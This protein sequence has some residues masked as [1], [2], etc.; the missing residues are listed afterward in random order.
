MKTTSVL[1][2]C[3][4]VLSVTTALGLAQGAV[5]PPPS[6]AKAGGVT[7]EGNVVVIPKPPDPVI[8]DGKNAKDLD[9][10]QMREFLESKIQTIYQSEGAVEILKVAP[11]YALT[12]TFNEPLSSVVVGDPALVNFN[13]KGKVLVLSA[14]ARAGDTSMQIILPGDRILNY[15]IFIAPNFADAQSTLNVIVGAG[16]RGGEGG[17]G[18]PYYRPDEGLD[19]RAIANIISN[20]DALIEEGAIS[21]SGI[22]R[23]GIF[24]KSDLTSFEYYYI[25]TFKGG[26]VAISFAYTNPFSYPIRYDESRLRLQMGNM[27]FIPDYVSFNKVDLGP[28]EVSTGFAVIADPGF[29]PSQPFELNW[30]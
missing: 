7:T 25:Y 11:G 8:V 30:K 2:V 3:A 28:G 9:E 29:V 27:L 17:G 5:P 21:K 15:H 4:S 24:R 6:G 23:L 19:V 14:N 12:M 18:S 10:D 20:Y 22:K 1:L 16:G 13:N 26:P